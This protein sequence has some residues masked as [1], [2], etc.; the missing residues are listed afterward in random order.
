MQNLLV[1]VLKAEN[2]PLRS[3]LPVDVE[4]MLLK[5]EYL[6]SAGDISGKLSVSA[7]DST[8]VKDVITIGVVSKDG[9][10]DVELFNTMFRTASRDRFEAFEARTA[11]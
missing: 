10:W 1:L 9:T 8:D 4:E 3:F 5:T 2:T 6:V 11:W 7:R